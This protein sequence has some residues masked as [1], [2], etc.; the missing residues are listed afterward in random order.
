MYIYIF[1]D[2]IT[3]KASKILSR[4]LL[5]Q[6]VL[7]Y[8]CENNLDAKI[9]DFAVVKESENEKPYFK[10]APIKFNISHSA[11]LWICAVSENE[12]GIDI[13]TFTDSDYDAVS[14]RYFTDDEI[15]LISEFGKE[16]FFDIWTRKEAY[17]KFYG[18]SIFRVISDIDTV[19]NDMLKN[20]IGN[21]NML[22]ID[23]DDN[24]KCTLA[25]EG[26]DVKIC[27]RN[28]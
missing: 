5:M 19:E 7:S 27:L 2:F 10:N 28:I 14:R 12:V 3:G 18:E 4:E 6:G 21:I 16:A 26:E 20:K 11:N 25:F 17:A 8:C 22:K 13:Q 9:F 24:A 15:N 23:I 1:K